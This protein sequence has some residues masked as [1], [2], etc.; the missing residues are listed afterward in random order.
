M[1]A[2]KHQVEKIKAFEHQEKLNK[3]AL[4]SWA[5]KQV[6]NIRSG[7]L[8]TTRFVGLALAAIL[9]IGLI[10]FLVKSGKSDKSRIWSD[11][12]GANSSKLLKDFV[13]QNPKSPVTKEARLQ[14]AR[15]QLGPEGLDRLSS[16]EKDQRTKAIENVEKGREEMTKLAEEFKDDLTLKV[17]CL[18]SAGEAELALVGI[19]A[20]STSQ[21]RG[22]V[23]KAVEYFNQVATVAGPTTP[24]GEAAKKKADDLLATREPIMMLGVRLNNL[25]STSALPPLPAGGFGA[26]VP[27]VNNPPVLPDLGPVPPKPAA[28]VVGGA[29]AVEPGKKEEAPAPKPVEK[30]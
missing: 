22:S 13:D 10:I 25:L 24:V 18:Q 23:E 28:A 12:A 20:E 26:P 1:N 17:L 4:Y 8:F 7:R 14:L 15:I 9:A 21:H 16:K 29:A 19:P 27:P 5:E 3:N 2:E 6:E 11:F 30:K